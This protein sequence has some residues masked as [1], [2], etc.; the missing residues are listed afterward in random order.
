MS[1]EEPLAYIIRGTKA[2]GSSEKLAQIFQTT[3]NNIS[4][5]SNIH[6]TAL[7]EKAIPAQLVNKF[8]FI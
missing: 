2:P 3:C 6:R 1:T 4:E 7:L 5:N 8:P